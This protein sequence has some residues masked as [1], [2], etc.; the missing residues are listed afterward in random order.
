VQTAHAFEKHEYSVSSKQISINL[1]N[2]GTDCSV[3]HFKINHNS[4]DFSSEFQIIEPIEKESIIVFSEI[5]IPSEKPF[6]KS[7]RAPPF[8]LI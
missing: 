2:K 4:I 3:F 7:S 5:Q 8:L 1:V 6:Y